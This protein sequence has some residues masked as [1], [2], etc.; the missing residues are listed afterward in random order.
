MGIFARLFHRE[1][2]PPELP[3]SVS[4]TTIKEVEE[5]EAV[6]PY[7]EAS[8]ED[9][10]LVSLIV[11]AIATGDQP[12]SQF[13]VKKILQRNPE[14]KLVSLIAT[15]IAAGTNESSQFVI[16]KIVKK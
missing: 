12:E 9:Y 11:T 13:V 3:T 4:E 2:Q 6:P 14:A 10:E 8:A 1:Q 16:R 15:S 7:I 5:W